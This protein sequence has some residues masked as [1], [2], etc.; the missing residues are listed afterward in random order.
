MASVS[1]NET[2]TFYVP[3]RASSKTNR[4]LVHPDVGKSRRPTIPLPPPDYAYGKAQIKTG[5]S[6]GAGMRSQVF[7]LT[8]CQKILDDF[9]KNQRAF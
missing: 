4:L 2:E 7:H 8:L 5:E 3:N 1:L 6:A 9:R